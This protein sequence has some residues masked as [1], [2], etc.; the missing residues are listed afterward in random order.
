MPPKSGQISKIAAHF[1]V[2]APTLQK[3][4]KGTSIPEP[5]RWRDLCTMLQ[6]SL[7]DLFLGDS[8][9]TPVGYIEMKIIDGIR[10][11][12]LKSRRIMI[13]TGDQCGLLQGY[14]LYRV[15]DDQMDP[16]VRPGDMVIINP[17]KNNPEA[18]TMMLFGLSNHFLIRR[19]QVMV[20]GEIILI[21]DNSKY[22]N[23]VL[24]SSS[25]RHDELKDAAAVS[26]YAIG[27]VVGRIL[28]N[29]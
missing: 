23:E 28:F 16:F 21:P 12:K 13:Q 22:N 11:G 10:N 25:V 26:P 8:S 20:S 17:G 15:T 5:H 7:D 18:S 27:S 14:F 24:L 2:S 6:C 3:W 29:S 1:C 9:Q 4:L 19:I